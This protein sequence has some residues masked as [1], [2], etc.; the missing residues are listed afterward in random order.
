MTNKTKVSNG[1]WSYAA[2]AKAAKYGLSADAKTDFA[3]I[4][5]SSDT[6]AIYNLLF[7]QLYDRHRDMPRPALSPIDPQ[8]QIVKIYQGSL[9]SDRI[10]QDAAAISQTREQRIAKALP[11]TGYSGGYDFARN[12]LSLGSVL[13]IAGTSTLRRRIF[14]WQLRT[15]RTP[16]SRCTASEAFIWRKTS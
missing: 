1:E 13:S 3:T 15:T 8:G 2:F 7:R 10:A 9:T 5:V 12:Y 6:C 14:S 11:F 16:R 4:P